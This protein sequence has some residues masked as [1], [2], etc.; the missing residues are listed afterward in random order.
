[1]VKTTRNNDGSYSHEIEPH[2]WHMA[3]MNNI[4][5][6]GEAASQMATPLADAARNLMTWVDEMRRYQAFLAGTDDTMDAQRNDIRSDIM[7][8]CAGMR[9]RQQRR[10]R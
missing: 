1:M 8:Q 4:N 3:L 10:R 6:T 7:R 9:R 5:R 2:E